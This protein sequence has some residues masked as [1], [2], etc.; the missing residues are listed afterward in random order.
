MVGGT[1][2]K[3]EQARASLTTVR[4]AVEPTKN[5]ANQEGSPPQPGRLV[6]K[7]G[8]SPASSHQFK[9][10]RNMDIMIQRVEFLA[11]GPGLSRSG[12]RTVIIT[13]RP[14]PGINFHPTILR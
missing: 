10:E 11:A 4:L 5:L 14:E 3:A 2:P 12:E 6:Q 7:N 1:V 13:I 8:H 9:K